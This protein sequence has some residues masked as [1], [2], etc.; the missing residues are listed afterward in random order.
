MVKEHQEKG[1]VTQWFENIYKSAK[2][3]YKEVFWADL[4]PSDYLL[5]WLEKDLVKKEKENCLRD[6]L[7]SW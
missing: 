6:W 1:Q 7:W 3:D 5:S 2:G 4:E